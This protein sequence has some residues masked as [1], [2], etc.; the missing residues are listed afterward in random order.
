MFGIQIMESGE[1][2]GFILTSMGK[3]LVF[4]SGGDAATHARWLNNAARN[5]SRLTRYKVGRLPNLAA[6]KSQDSGTVESWY[7]REIRRFARG[8]Y[9]PAPWAG[10]SWYL[11]SQF[12]LRHYCHISID[13]PGKV[14]FTE[15]REKGVEDL[16]LRIRAGRYLHQFYSHVLPPDKIAFWSA[17]VSIATGDPL[18]KFATTADEIEHVYLTGPHSCMA[19]SAGGYGGNMNPTRVYGAGDLAVAYIMAGDDIAARVLCWPDKKQYGRIYGDGGG[20]DS[21]LGAMLRAMGYRNDWNFDGARLLKIET[22]G[23][24]VC[25]FLDGGNGVFVRGGFLIISESDAEYSADSEYG[26]VGEDCEREYCPNCENYYPEGSGHHIQDQG[27]RWCDSCYENNSQNCDSCE[28]NFSDRGV[29]HYESIGRS[30]CESC[31]ADYNACSDCGDLQSEH[32]DLCEINGDVIC[33][34]CYS[35]G[36]CFQCA[37]CGDHCDSAENNESI[38]R[39]ES[40]CD[41]CFAQHKRD[42][43]PQFFLTLGT[44][45][46]WAKHF[47]KIGV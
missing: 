36:N 30:L 20:Y 11:N 24:Y 31:A 46:L 14:A 15:S 21:E 10:E 8:E 7:M 12:D 43:A 34:H 39:D 16:Q 37:E 35:R 47:Q 17:K 25:P 22:C 2:T 1:S 41:S 38:D 27:E 26:L 28:N 5:E 33:S 29:D 13:N 6:E 4:E 18:V 9:T 45:I 23:G 32:S 44:R 3:P 42:I 40:L 19:K